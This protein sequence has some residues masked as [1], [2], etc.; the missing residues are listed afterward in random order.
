MWRP[1][2]T[3]CRIRIAFIRIGPMHS[4]GNTRTE[5]SERRRLRQQRMLSGAQMLLNN[6]PIC[7]V[8]KVINAYMKAVAM[9]NYNNYAKGNA[10]GNGT[11][12]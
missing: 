5:I 12:T 11:S 9:P 8:I 2:N 1:S 7:Q 4:N 3:C 10:E 6:K